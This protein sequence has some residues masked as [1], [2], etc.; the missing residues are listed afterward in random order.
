MIRFK[1]FFSKHKKGV[2]FAV[3]IVISFLFLMFS[4][5]SVVLKP[6]EIGL[7]FFSLFQ[8]AF[9]KTGG[10]ISS[11]VN[12]IGELNRLK[13]EYDKAKERLRNFDL[14][15]RDNLNLKQEN[16][17]LKEQLGFKESLQY[18]HITAEVIGKDPENLYSTIVINKGS[19]DGIKKDMPVIAYQDGF[20]GLVGKTMNVGINA[21]AVLPLYDRACFVS[22]RFHRS[23]YEGIINGMGI[24]DEKLIMRYIKKR[25]KNE[26]QYGDL[27]VTSG[28]N[29]LYPKDIYIGR[30]KGISAKEYDTSLEVELEPIIDFSKL[31]YVFVIGSEVD[32]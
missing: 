14:M 27:I 29:S 8:T 10:W 11:T 17:R 4:T 32:E 23:R 15:E 30:V 2:T 12:S 24:S 3:L 18:R 25:A 1:G 28:L 9:T 7:S 26:I 13:A 22:A 31:E 5:K 20:Q 16:L 19:R 21:T 6:K